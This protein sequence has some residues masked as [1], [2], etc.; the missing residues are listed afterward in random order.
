MVKSN[1]KAIAVGAGHERPLF[2]FANQ[3]TK[4]VATDL[5]NNWGVDGDSSMLT[6]PEKFTPFPY[7]N[8]NLEV[9]QMNGTDLK[10]ADNSFD[11]AFTLSSIEHFGSRENV[12]EA[13]SEICRVLKPGGVLCLTTELILNNSHHPE[14]FT[15]DELRKYILESTEMKVVGGEIDLRISRSI[16][17]NPIELDIEKDLNISP[18]IVLKQGNVIWTS[19]ICFLQKYS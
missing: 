12:R 16:V 19:I 11:F 17:L 10:F 13:M 8:E 9:Y 7:R 18:H 15:F 1:S 6:T 4:M 2:Y 14:Y 5:Y 3:I